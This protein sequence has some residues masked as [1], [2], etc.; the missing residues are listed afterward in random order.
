MGLCSTMKNLPS[1]CAATPRYFSM[2]QDGT[3]YTT[4]SAFDNQVFLL[5]EDGATSHYSWSLRP[6]VALLEEVTT[7][8]NLVPNVWLI[9]ARRVV[10]KGRSFVEHF[11]HLFDLANHGVFHANQVLFIVVTLSSPFQTMPGIN[12]KQ[13]LEKASQKRLCR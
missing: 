7:L 3:A 8:N 12:L 1:R 6:G 11:D 2:S 10:G 5:C 13:T 4:I 9:P